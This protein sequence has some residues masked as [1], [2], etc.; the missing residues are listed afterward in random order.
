MNWESKTDFMAI[1]KAVKRNNPQIL[2]HIDAVQAYLKEPISLCEG[3]IDFL[4]ASGH[5]DTC[6]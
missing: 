5:Y 2:I 1:A 6:S 4:S 3:V